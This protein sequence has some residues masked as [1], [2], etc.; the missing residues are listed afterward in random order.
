MLLHWWR[1]C[2][3]LTLFYWWRNWGPGSEFGQGAQVKSGRT[4]FK[5]WFLYALPAPRSLKARVESLAVGSHLGCWQMP[6]N[7]TT[8][9]GDWALLNRR[10]TSPWCL[11]GCL[12]C[13]LR[14]SSVSGPVEN[15]GFP[16]IISKS[17]NIWFMFFCRWMKQVWSGRI[18]SFECHSR[19]GFG[20]T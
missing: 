1:T 14:L 2:E 7:S 9:E 20:K 5:P 10:G 6:L 4:R 13:P 3:P 11:V 8:L 15:S 16:G 19:A 12:D 18:M 17:Y